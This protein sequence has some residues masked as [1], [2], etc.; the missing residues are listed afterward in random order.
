MLFICT[1]IKKC[2]FYK[3]VYNFFS[4]RGILEDLV[5]IL[6]S[7]DTNFSFLQI[8]SGFSF[9]ELDLLDLLSI[10]NELYTPPFIQILF[11]YVHNFKKSV[12]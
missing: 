4:P 8:F 5:K 6:L 11:Q 7:N 9:Y 3:N 12:K 10:T 2:I 1:T